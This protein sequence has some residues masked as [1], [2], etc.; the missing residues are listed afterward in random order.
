MHLERFNTFGQQ[1]EFDGL[2][3][4]ASVREETSGIASSPALGVCD[5][6]SERWLALFVENG[7]LTLQHGKVKI[8]LDVPGTTVGY[9]H[10]DGGVTQ[11]QVSQGGRLGLSLSYP[12]WWTHT[13]FVAGFG[14]GPDD[15]NDFCA[16]LKFMMDSEATRKHLRSMYCP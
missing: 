13:Q 7:A 3:G 2:T 12:S 8:D 9:A 1:V 11:F 16:Y 5:L 4:D 6:V 10:L 14:S 15:E